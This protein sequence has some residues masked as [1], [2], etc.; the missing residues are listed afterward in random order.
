MGVLRYIPCFFFSA[1]YLTPAPMWAE[2]VPH[3]EFQGISNR[4]M[5]IP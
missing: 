2:Q 3:H 1:L 4:T 5:R